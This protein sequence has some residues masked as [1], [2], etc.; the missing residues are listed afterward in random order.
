MEVGIG[1]NLIGQDSL[2]TACLPA[3]ARARPKILEPVKTTF[4][5]TRGRDCEMRDRYKV[6]GLFGAEPINVAD[7]HHDDRMADKNTSKVAV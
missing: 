2:A 4:A 5:T 7:S 3:S 6:S 1:R